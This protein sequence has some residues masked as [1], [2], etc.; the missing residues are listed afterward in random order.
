MSTTTPVKTDQQVGGFSHEALLYADDDAYVKATT[1]FIRDALDAQSPLMVAIGAEK[2]ERLRAGLG[3]AADRVRFVDMAVV[4]S[5]PARI[6][7]AW[8]EFVAEHWTPGLGVR[9]IGEPIWAGRSAAELV[10]CQR[11]E[12]LLNLAFADT[13][14]FKLLCPYDTRALP[15]EVIH[16]AACSH[17]ILVEDGTERE[18]ADYRGLDAIAGPF[19]VPLP[20]RPESAHTLHFTGVTLHAVR[21]LVTEEAQRAGLSGRRSTDLVIAVNEMAANS[22]RHGGGAGTLFMWADHGFLL[23]DVVDAGRMAAPLAGRERPSPLQTS[24]WG[25]WLANQLCDL[26]QVRTLPGGNVVRLHM[27]V[28]RRR[29]R[30]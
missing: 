28:V 23:C 4:G 16:E 22:I 30:R 13:T 25:L 24:G 1:A 5:N 14:R 10:E 8:R 7:P 11:H 9:G 21:R 12:S 15:A 26:V 3:A 2:I 17:P 19:E 20:P 27:A 6:I 18:S 29:R